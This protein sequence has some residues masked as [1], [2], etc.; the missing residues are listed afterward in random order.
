LEQRTA[1]HPEAEKAVVI[2]KCLRML[3]I[4]FND[5]RQL[6]GGLCRSALL[7]LTHYFEAV[8]GRKLVPGVIAGIQTF[9][10]RI[11]LHPPPPFFGD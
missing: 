11:N 8:T 1:S 9:G 6:L 2:S 3:W 4:F 5:K 10:N 7:S